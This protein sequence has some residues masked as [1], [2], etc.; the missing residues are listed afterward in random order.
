[1]TTAAGL[2]GRGRW[3]H[4]VSDPGLWWSLAARLAD[5]ERYYRD[6]PLQFGPLSPY[7]LSLSGRVFGFSTRYFL[8]SNWI[9]AILAGFLLLRAARPFLSVLE[10]LSAVGLLLGLAIFAPGPGRLVYPYSPA[11]VHALCF[12]LAALLIWRPGPAAKRSNFWSGL[13]AGMAF[14]AKQEIGIAVLVALLVGCAVS[15]ESRRTA[16][17]RCAIGFS[18]VLVPAAAFAL[19]SAPLASLRNDSHLW[20]LSAVP[21]EWVALYRGVAGMATVDW[22]KQVLEAARRLI[23]YVALFAMLGLLITRERRVSRWL[24]VAVLSGATLL[25]DALEGHGLQRQFHPM[26]LATAIAFLV[27]LL[28]AIRRRQEHRGFLVSLGL[29]AGIVGLRTVFSEELGGPYAAVAHLCTGLTWAVFLLVLL[30]DLLLG[31]G[32]AGLCAR[33]LLAVAL[34]GV[35]W[36]GAWRGIESLARADRTPVET[37]LGRIWLEAGDAD[38]FRALGRELR[39]G[40]RALVLPETNGVDLLY[41]VKSASPYLIHMPGSLDAFTERKLLVRFDREPPDVVVLFKRSTA[42]YRVQP[43]G[44]GFGRALA[45]WIAR[46]YRVVA[47][48]SA[49]QILRRRVIEGPSLQ[50]ARRYNSAT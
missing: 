28:A 43:F 3:V 22:S 19:S 36:T 34:F 11:A 31:S 35:A 32:S 21:P 13:L 23:A 15:S 50:V 38:F 16:F 25:G 26:Y 18:F 39:P 45:D 1:M 44:Q 10:R 33:R 47:E 17:V 8:L 2:W 40:E 14:A 46:N 27:A 7:L 41:R 29:F 12:A 49:G 48:G 24:P 37:R 4:P 42:E 6:I 9:P 30:P 20:P 5:G